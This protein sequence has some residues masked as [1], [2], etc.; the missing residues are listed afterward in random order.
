MQTKRE[1]GTTWHLDG[2]GQWIEERNCCR[3][4]LGEGRAEWAET[5]HSFGIYAGRYCDRHWRTSG[6]RDAIDPDAEFDELDAGE[7]LEPE[8]DY[9]GA[10]DGFTVSSDA[11]SGL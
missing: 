9:G 8:P 3:R 2:S 7:R 5:R 1:H 11:D 4:C 6:Y 10:F